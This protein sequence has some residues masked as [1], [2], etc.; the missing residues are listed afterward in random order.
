MQG[1][2]CEGSM[3]G[4]HFADIDVHGR[5]LLNEVNTDHDTMLSRLPHELAPEAHQRSPDHL[6]PRALGEI[7]MRVTRSIATRD[8][9]ER[10]HLFYWNGLGSG[11]PDDVD[12]AGNLEHR[13][14]GL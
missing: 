13:I 7:R 5:G 9:L 14:A 1:N 10:V 8:H 3:H 6:D 2:D 4:G 12:D 11:D